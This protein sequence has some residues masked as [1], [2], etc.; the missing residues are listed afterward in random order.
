LLINSY[1]SSNKSENTLTKIEYELLKEE[2]PYFDESKSIDERVNFLLYMLTTEEKLKLL[3]A[4]RGTLW[5]TKSIRRLRIKPMGMTDGPF[6]VAFHSSLKRNTKF[7]VSICLASTWNRELAEKQGIAMGKETRAVGRHIILGPGINIQR[8]PLNGRTFEY[9]SEDPFLSGEL[10]SFTVKGIQNQQ[11]AAC[12]KHYA[13]NNQETKRHHVSSEVDERTLHEIY[14]KAFEIVVKKSDPWSLMSS[15]NRINGKYLTDD[16]NLLKETLMEKWGFNGFVVT[17]WWATRRALRQGSTPESTIKAGLSLEMPETII[18]R[19]DWLRKHLNAGKITED[20][21]NYV[22]KRLLKVMFQVGLFD[23]PKTIPK[24]ERNTK[25]HQAISRKIAEEGIVLLK[26][27][28]NT[29]PLNLNTM[30]SIAVLGPNKNRKMGY[31]LYGGAAA[32]HPPFE[33]TPLKGMKEKCKGKVN[34]TTDPKK[35]DVCILFLGLNHNRTNDCENFDRKRLEL[36]KRQENLIRKTVQQNPKTIVVLINGSPI[37]M[38]EW[39][40]T[41]PAVVEAWYPGMEAGRT[42]ADVLF[43]DVNPSGKLPITFPKKLSDSPAHKSKRTFPGN[44]KVYYDEGIF[45]G[46]RYFE[47]E[48]IEPLFPFGFGLSYTTFE[49]SNM[50]TNSETI[51]KDKPVIVS[52]DVENTGELNGSEIVQ[53]YIGDN[54]T[55]VPRPPKEL[56]NFSKISLNPGEKKTVELEVTINDLKFYDIKIHEWLS[57]P[58]IFTIYI[59]SSSRD[60][61][62]KQKIELKE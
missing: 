22:I 27:D 48:N 25:E 37:D 6:G 16:I 28:Q 18:Y 45:V 21:L 4:K 26:N 12:I 9:L 51:T 46:Y 41:V 40:E 33:I 7:P 19:L 49:Y 20:D 15:Y 56:K 2:F 8:S 60:I 31:M 42:I 24:G 17:D 36:P 1:L 58:G 47:N 11:I 52:V 55:N 50:T 38:S 62:F 44:D 10:A 3:S 53:L 30:K 34:I 59:G 32:V 61:Y 13:C 29:L 39:I 23:N 43:G 14:L 35:A 57:E 5:T 54:N